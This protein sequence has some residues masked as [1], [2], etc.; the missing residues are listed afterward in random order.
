MTQVY[1][2]GLTPRQQGEVMIDKREESLFLSSQK[3]AEWLKISLAER[4]HP[5]GSPSI[6]DRGIA[7]HTQQLEVLWKSAWECAHEMKTLSWLETE[8]EF[9]IMLMRPSSRSWLCG[10]I[11]KGLIQDLLSLLLKDGLS[12][13]RV[14][15]VPL[16]S[17]LSVFL[18]LR[19]MFSSP[20]YDGSKGQYMQL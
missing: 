4:W 7:L 16:C 14:S 5:P 18:G 11:L 20:S 12:L 8:V 10:F 19:G 2:F 17:P 6:T 13:S 3:R 9:K 15:G 1:C